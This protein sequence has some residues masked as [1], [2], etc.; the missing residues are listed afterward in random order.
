MKKT[1]I[2][3]LFLSNI[4]PL[5]SQISYG[6]NFGYSY[7]KSKNAGDYIKGYDYECSPLRKINYEIFV[8]YSIKSYQ[9]K[10]TAGQSIL[11][12]VSRGSQGETP[13]PF[14]FGYPDSLPIRFYEFQSNYY[15]FMRLSGNY[16][17]N[18]K[19]SIGLGFQYFWQKDYFHLFGNF[20]KSDNSTTYEREVYVI[21]YAYRAKWVEKGGVTVYGNKRKNYAITLNF[22]YNFTKNLYFETD[23]LRGINNYSGNTIGVKLY[24]Q[25]IILKLGATFLLRKNHSKK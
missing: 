18:N 16:S 22:K 21:G 14:L 5:F 2:F 24:H 10:L 9:A 6:F 17:I 13:H 3:L 15:N 4:Y 12:F 20:F 11:G 25:A 23:F 8:A 7:S 19:I 1:I